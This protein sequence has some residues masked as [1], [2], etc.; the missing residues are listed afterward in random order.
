MRG[1]TSH[2][3]IRLVSTL[4]DGWATSRRGADVA[5]L[6]RPL[7]FA[8]LPRLAVTLVLSLSACLHAPQPRIGG[9]PAAPASPADPWRVPRGSVPPEPRPD[10]ASA[11]A[12]LPSEFALRADPLMLGDVVDIALRNNPQ[13]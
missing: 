1:L 3:Y 10:P 6:P 9:Q 5:R 2:S 12:A 8:P 4:L 13:T 11:R 7:R